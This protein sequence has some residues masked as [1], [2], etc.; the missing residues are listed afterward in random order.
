ME[1]IVGDRQGASDQGRLCRGERRKVSDLLAVAAGDFTIE[2]ADLDI[3][4]F[5]L[6]A[7]LSLYL[8]S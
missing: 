1:S 6:K 2:Q 4:V 7:T 5:A 8:G 3:H